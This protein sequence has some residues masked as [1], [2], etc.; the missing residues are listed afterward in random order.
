MADT[1]P[2]PSKRRRRG[3]GRG[4][5]GG[6]GGGG[7]GGGGGGGG[8]PKVPRV[9]GG[10]ESAPMPPPPPQAERPRP[11]LEGSRTSS[12]TLANMTQER[13]ADLPVAESTKRAL[14]EVFGYELMTKPLTTTCFVRGRLLGAMT[15]GSQWPAVWRI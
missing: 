7:D 13:F 10:L 9:D 1:A 14:A 3:R 2:D 15:Q 5:G 4:R 12:T 6:E 11:K 8:R